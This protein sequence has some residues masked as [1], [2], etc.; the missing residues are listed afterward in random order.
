MEAKV[1]EAKVLEART[2]DKDSNV[3]SVVV[4]PGNVVEN[5]DKFKAAALEKVEVYK[6]ADLSTLSVKEAKSA[7][8]YLNAEAKRIDDDRKHWERI[9][10]E[11]FVIY[12][13]RATEL[14]KIF[15]EEADRL[16]K[17]INEA[18]EFGRNDRLNLYEAYYNSNYDLLAEVVPFSK[19]LNDRWLNKTYKED[20][21]NEIDKI[22]N[23]VAA[24]WESLKRLN[25]DNAE[26]AELVFFKT[27]DLSE[28][29]AENDR[30]T[31][32]R[33]K[34]EKVKAAIAEQKEKR[35]NQNAIAE[36]AT[37]PEATPVNEPETQQTDGLRFVEEVPASK[38]ELQDFII[39]VKCTLESA[40]TL[41]KGIKDRGYEVKLRRK[42]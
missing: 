7:R 25:L 31:A 32:E 19:I 12:K 8:A 39:E 24:N 34:L 37:Q 15:K 41:C 13:N 1:L 9:Y 26:Q 42:I 21:T 33:V 3:L 5:F 2:A 35:N 11:P 23:T 6:G 38:P 4:T 27:L 17:L 10:N 30:I 14:V 40:T 16:G 18:E 22:A 36:T 29:I 20:P 28:A